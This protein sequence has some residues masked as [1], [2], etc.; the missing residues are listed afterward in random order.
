[1]QPVCSSFYLVFCF[2]V[3]F[4]IKVS[5]SG[6]AGSLLLR[7]GFLKLQQ[8][9]APVQMCCS[10]FS[11][12][13]LLLLQSTG[14]RHT[15]LAAPQHVGSS[16]SRDRSMSPALAGGFSTTEPT[17]KSNVASNGPCLLF[18]SKTFLWE[19]LGPPLQS[20]VKCPGVYTLSGSQ[21]SLAND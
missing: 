18:S 15:G 9:Q 2:F 16:P 5:V 19:L 1:M 12:R 6:Y 11:W 17:A 21:Q 3:F 13:W 4:L 10:A 20:A 8:P 7:A 14:S